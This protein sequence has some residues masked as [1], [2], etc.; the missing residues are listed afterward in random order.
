MCLPGVLQHMLQ[1][2]ATS[3]TLPSRQHI[4]PT[5]A[6]SPRMLSSSISSNPRHR[7]SKRHRPQKV[8]PPRLLPL[9]RSYWPSP[10]TWSMLTPE[11]MLTR[12]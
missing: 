5:L 12:R 7:V 2:L 8:P 9:T 11:P 10:A 3:L 4:Q 6:L 1:S